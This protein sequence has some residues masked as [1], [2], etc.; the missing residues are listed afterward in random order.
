[1]CG[2]EGHKSEVLWTAS[3][4]DDKFEWPFDGKHC[5]TCHMLS[6]TNTL[7]YGRIKVTLRS[8]RREMMLHNCNNCEVLLRGIYRLLGK[9]IQRQRRDSM[10]ESND[11]AQQAIQVNVNMQAT[12]AILDELE[13]YYQSDPSFECP[14]SMGGWSIRCSCDHR[15]CRHER[16]C[17]NFD[18]FTLSETTNV[19]LDFPT[20]PASLIESGSTASTGTMR[21]IADCI[22]RCLDRHGIACNKTTRRESGTPIRVLELHDNHVRLV[23]PPQSE[24]L[25]YICLAHRW[26]STTSQ[27]EGIARTNSYS[28]SADCCTLKDNIKRHEVGIEIGDLLPAYRDAVAVARSLGVRYLWIDSLCIVQD[29]DEDKAA[30]ISAMG[31]IYSNSYL[32][33]AADCG[34]DHT[35]SIF[36]SRSWH[37]QAHEES[38]EKWNGSLQKIYFR[39]RP[40]HGHLSWSGIFTR[41][42]CFQERLLSRRVVRFQPGEVI[43]ECNE[44]LRCECGHPPAGHQGPWECLLQSTHVHDKVAFSRMLSLRNAKTTGLGK[45]TT[46]AQLWRQLVFSYS[47]THLTYESDRMNA[48][49]GIVSL[50]QSRMLGNSQYLAGLWS[51]SLWGD[52]LWTSTAA[53][54]THFTKSDLAVHQPTTPSWSWMSISLGYHLIT[55]PKL[56]MQQS[57]PRLL[58]MKYE[59]QSRVLPLGDVKAGAYLELEGQLASSRQL[60]GYKCSETED[61]HD[62]I[63]PPGIKVHMDAG[64]HPHPKIDDMD[65]L[66]RV[67]ILRDEPIVQEVFLIL[68]AIIEPGPKNE[69]QVPCFK[70]IGL[71]TFSRRRWYDWENTA[72]DFDETYRRLRLY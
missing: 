18:V 45:D 28:S 54:M 34:G 40:N 29:D 6:S 27:M 25:R 11:E 32:T 8:L 55:H 1:M 38:L 48:L 13:V 23:K 59:P 67:A 58:G 16:Y 69:A 33:I 2:G 66:L 5:S 60:H 12:D 31:A 42:W 53:N 72:L 65:C 37:W 35:E 20:R 44:D 24:G 14:Y 51:H 10:F 26:L 63:L 21:F 9:P 68:R 46:D 39:E 3:D 43:F 61:P 22:E 30:Q 36:S 56:P 41:A 52:M 17:M 7:E 57:F 4:G 49:A 62:I 50:F 19:L 15:R 71:L 64:R 70:R 47:Q